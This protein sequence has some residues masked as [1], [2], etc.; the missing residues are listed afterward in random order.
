MRADQASAT[1][2]APAATERSTRRSLPIGFLRH[3]SPHQGWATLAIVLATLLVVGQSVACPNWFETIRGAEVRCFRWVEMPGIFPTL[4]LSTL[5]GLLLAKIRLHAIFLHPL[6]LLIGAL[7]VIFFTA[8]LMDNQSGNQEYSELWE[9]LTLWWD[10]AAGGGIS[11][12]LV[13][14][15]MMV[16]AIAWLLGY[17]SAWFIFR[18]GNVWVAVIVLGTAILTILSFLPRSLGHWFFIFTFCTMLLVVHVRFVQL[19]SLWRRA[20]KV[21]D[22]T[23]GWHTLHATAWLSLAV[24]LL[25]AFLPLVTYKNRTAA[26]VWNRGRAPVEV[27]QDEFARL[28]SGIPTRKDLSG[29]FFGKTLPFLGKVSFGGE[30][31]FWTDA[32]HP[33]YWT[34]S[35]YSEYT[36][37]GWKA[38]ETQALE[39][40]PDLP[41]PPTE[42]SLGRV[43]S[44]QSLQL[45]FDTSAFLA[46]GNLDWISESAVVHTLRPKRFTID[47]EDSSGDVELPDDI[48]QLAGQMRAAFTPPPAQQPEAYAAQLIP[49]DLRLVAVTRERGDSENELRGLVLERKGPVSPDVVG[50]KFE[51]RLTADEAYAMVSYVSVVSDDELRGASSEYSSFIADHYLQLPSSLPQRV[52]DLAQSVTQ[53]AETPLDKTVAIRDYLRSPLFTYS[54]EIDRPPRGTDGV[55]YFLFETREGYSDYFASSMA[56]LLRAAGV[57]ARLAAGYGPGEV[58]PESDLRM[59]RDSDSHGWVQVYFPEYGW[60][61][62]EPTPSF[63]VHSRVP[64]IEELAGEGSDVEV[65]SPDVP[66][67]EFVFDLEEDILD[68][69]GILT[70]PFIERDLRDWTGIAVRTAITVG[71]IGL[72]VLLAMAIWNIGLS[73]LS[74]VEQAYLKMNRLSRFAGLRRSSDQTPTEYAETIGAALPALAGPAQRVCWALASYR[75]SSRETTAEETEQIDD[76]W[77]AMRISLIMRALSRLIPSGPKDRE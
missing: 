30:V 13:P 49:D 17:T 27:I 70:G 21:F 44:E 8:S 39:V 69:E 50:H 7:A 20:G 40:G 56:V 32:E 47:L 52:R 62:F 26:D 68:E 31:V 55:D 14:F 16:L 37:K 61:D 15:S 74:P 12:D 28:F 2:G 33:S 45:T 75:Y 67:G 64:G 72:V 9:R 6:G 11:T 42:D 66:G 1:F 54:Q 63:P 57:P 51:R 23:R 35:T 41:A 29:R 34:S 5:C 18:S 59:V 60:I 36:S 38:G 19:H 3:L 77:K 43:R 58:H 53:G 71:A 10:A 65:S 24:I 46:G 73:N 76:S 22:S 4:I 25:A 48:G